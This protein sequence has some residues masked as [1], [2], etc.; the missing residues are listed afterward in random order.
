MT[1][2]RLPAPK[3]SLAPCSAHVR[4]L[5]ANLPRRSAHVGT[6]ALARLAPLAAL[7]AG[8][9]LN[10]PYSGRSLPWAAQTSRVSLPFAGC[11]VCVVWSLP[12]ARCL[13][14]VSPPTI[15][16]DPRPSEGLLSRPR[17]LAVPCHLLHTSSCPT[18]LCASPSSAI[19]LS[20]V[21][22]LRASSLRLSTTHRHRTRA[23]DLLSHPRLHLRSR[24]RLHR[25]NLVD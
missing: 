9:D 4:P 13:P 1:G 22:L 3:S 23:V 11:F 20:T 17:A 10:A 8:G 7:P 12:N 16:R 18:I 25:R 5:L 24:L 15:V 6:A 14:F 21:V 2:R 19:L